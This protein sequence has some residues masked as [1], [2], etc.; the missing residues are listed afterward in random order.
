[1]KRIR[2][3]ALFC[4]MLFLASCGKNDNPYRVDTVVRIP[5]N[6]TE[7]AETSAPTESDPTEEMTEATGTTEATEPEKASSAAK[8][9]S[10]GKTSSGKKTESESPTEKLV[11]SGGIS[12][13]Q[14]TEPKITGSLM[15]SQEPKPT[16]APE[17]AA[18]TETPYD[19]DDYS[20]G[21]LEYA[22]L[23]E[24]NARR[25]AEGLPE[26]AMNSR[27]CGIAALRAEEAA[28]LWSHTR[29]DGRNYTTAM[30]DYGFGFGTSAE[31]LAHVSGSGDAAAIVSK[32]MDTDSRNSILGDGFTTAAV[33][34]YRAGGV[35][36]V[37][38][39]LVG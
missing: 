30:S 35:T 16:E 33:G 11:L 10:G 4:C 18:P 22:I 38:N 27:L 1:M 15:T 8:S 20:V 37:V 39:L 6:P 12:A 19:P 32:W 3:L 13:V 2:I 34:V 17:T 14:A 31:N 26:L 36:Y 25:A 24:L 9:S 28:R 29:P 21:N 5:V 7:A 23:D